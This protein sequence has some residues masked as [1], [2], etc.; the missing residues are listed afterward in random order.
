VKLGVRVAH[1][2]AGLRSFDRTMPE[3]INRILTDAIADLCFVTEPAGRRNLEAEGVPAEKIRVVG[4][5]MIDTLRRELRH[6]RGLETWRRLG[7][8]PG[9]FGLVTMHRPSNVD[10]AETLER[11][12]RV[13][14]AL[15]EQLPL[16]MPMHPRTRA[17]VERFGL[18]GVYAGARGLRVLE[19]LSYRE[20]LC[21]MAAAKVVLTDSGG[22]QEESSI[23]GVPCLTMR[24]N[25]ERPIT[26]EQG[27]CRLVGND[28]EMIQAA[29]ADA[30][31]GRW[32]AA[33][34]IALWDGEAAV[35]IAEE[36]ER[37]T[38]AA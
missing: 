30:M 20:N 26:V 21:L 29:F 15:S 37:W 27:S 4:N 34:E 10:D 32:R 19:P 23:L 33:K 35:R 22:M 6:A 8:E 11:V 5:V 3:E 12:S 7:L 25:T 9:S 24:V 17:A 31:A 38:G 16:V 1:V 36:V 28:A 14:A 18:G 2:E 13:L